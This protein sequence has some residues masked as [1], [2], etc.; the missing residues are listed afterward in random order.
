VLVGTPEG[1]LVKGKKGPLKEGE[2]ERAAGWARSLL[3]LM[4]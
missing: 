4:K 2:L 1:F 3:E